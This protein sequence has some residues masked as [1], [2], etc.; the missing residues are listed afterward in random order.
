MKKIW[1]WIMTV[2]FVL[3]IICESSTA[4]QE[5]SQGPGELYARS[6]VLMDGSSGRILFGKNENEVLPMASTT[7]IMTCILTLE[8]ASIEEK[9]EISAYAAAQPEVRLGMQKGEQYRLK[10]LL[11]SL[12]LESHNDSAVAIAEH[13][14]GSVEKFAE[15]MNEK[16]ALLGCSSTHY[17]TP[18]G[19]DDSDAGGDHAT[20]AVEL[21]KVMSYCI[22]QSPQRDIFL[23]IT[24]TRSYSFTDLSGIR[25][26]S[27][28]NHNA[29]LDMMDGAISGKTGF[30]SAA[31]YCYVGAAENQGRTFVV[32]LLA[33]GWP[34]NKTYKWSDTLALMKYGIEHFENRIVRYDE[35]EREIVVENGIAASGDPWEKATTIVCADFSSASRQGYLLTKEEKI[36]RRAVLYKHLQAPL[37]DGETVGTV[38]Y[39]L[40]D[41]LLEKYP[42]VVKRAVKECKAK[43]WIRWILGHYF[44]C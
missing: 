25:N 39:Y 15:M 30:T 23:E 22:T 11:Y 8:N 28:R 31:G 24:Q 19:L 4:A 29:F 7:K 10:D 33:C 44:L 37:Q 42:I 20:T 21:A 13:V 26:F 3:A 27:C 41:I 12:M 38:S 35:I 36:T 14:G 40:G 17:V 2:T 16:A 6:A 9:V 32:A 5:N 18:N 34:H 43:H 1:S